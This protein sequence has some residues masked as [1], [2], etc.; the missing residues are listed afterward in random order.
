MI[1]I[2]LML[3]VMLLL[4]KEVM[5]QKMTRWGYTWVTEEYRGYGLRSQY[6]TLVE[7]ESQLQKAELA[8]SSITSKT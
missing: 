6:R 5:K 7:I 2:C 4:L 8:F 1:F 3:G